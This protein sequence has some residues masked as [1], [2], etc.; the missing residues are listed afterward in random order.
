M[1]GDATWPEWLRTCAHC[2]DDLL[3]GRRHPV[4]TTRD[5]SGDLSLHSFCDSDCRAAWT[6]P[7]G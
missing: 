7:D 6:G 4:E 3:D 5:A 2:G 1:T